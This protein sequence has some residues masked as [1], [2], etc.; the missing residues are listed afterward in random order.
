M[1]GG[2]PNEFMWS[3]IVQLITVASVHAECERPPPPP[4]LAA[5]TCLEVPHALCASSVELPG[6]KTLP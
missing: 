5:I 1:A 3:F 6:L 2:E 4:P